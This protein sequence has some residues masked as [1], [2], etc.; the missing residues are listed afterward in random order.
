M[1]KVN[2]MEFFAEWK[3]KR[4]VWWVILIFVYMK[5]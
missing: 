5:L 4:W 2:I 3:E 1:D